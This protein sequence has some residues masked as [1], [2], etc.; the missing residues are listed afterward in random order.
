MKRKFFGIY[1]AVVLIF[2][3]FSNV[4]VSG[5]NLNKKNSGDCSSSSAQLI[6]TTEMPKP[7]N[8]FN[9]EINEKTSGF[10][11]DYIEWRAPFKYDYSWKFAVGAGSNAANVKVNKNT[12]VNNLY[13][14]HNGGSA[15]GW[16]AAGIKIWN[17]FTTPKA[18]DS[19]ISMSGHIKGSLTGGFESASMVWGWIQIYD[20]W[21]ESGEEPLI[22]KK[23]FEYSTTYKGVIDTD[24]SGSVSYHFNK[25]T[26]TVL[27]DASAGSDGYSGETMADFWN[28]DYV[29]L[30]YM[31]VYLPEALEWEPEELRFTGVKVGE[32]SSP[33][34]VT[35][36]NKCFL[37]F[38]GE[39]YESSDIFS[40]TEGGGRFTLDPGESRTVK[41]KFCPDDGISHY[42]WLYAH[43]DD[44]LW[45]HCSLYGKGEKSRTAERANLV[46]LFNILE[47]LDL[48]KIFYK[49]LFKL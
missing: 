31:R 49:I 16:A 30:E 33:K 47:I 27:F 7:S 11:D 34:S 14:Y 39:I 46:D 36:T 4:V 19:T 32:C 29:K 45:V 13:T 41:V 5:N 18:F 20:G 38:S 25:G 3:V 42:D 22:Q 28:T 35:L 8:I 10:Y 43:T 1:V 24:F 23:I 6:G 40:I 44:E 26:Y 37:T 2:C 17:Q 21:P 48:P 9:E 15:Y 12:G